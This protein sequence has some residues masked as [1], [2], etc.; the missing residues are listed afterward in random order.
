MLPHK[1]DEIKEAKRRIRLKKQSAESLNI[2]N[3]VKS[4]RKEYANDGTLR[5]IRS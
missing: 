5:S 3:L 2:N 4:L 1:V